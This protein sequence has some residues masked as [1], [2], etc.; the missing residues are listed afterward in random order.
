MVIM[1]SIYFLILVTISGGRESLKQDPI[2]QRQQ[3]RRPEHTHDP[4][5]PFIPTVQVFSLTPSQLTRA[6]KC[7][8]FIAAFDTFTS[9]LTRY[10]NLNVRS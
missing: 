3:T 9:L 4:F 10:G 2:S 7:V 5:P 8:N 6:R 1:R